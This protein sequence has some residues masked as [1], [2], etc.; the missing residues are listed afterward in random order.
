MWSMVEIL[1]VMVVIQSN[2]GLST[3][4][5]YMEALECLIGNGD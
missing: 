2:R 4:D 5:E 1:Y 3:L